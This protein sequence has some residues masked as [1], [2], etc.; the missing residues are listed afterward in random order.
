MKY[1]TLSILLIIIVACSN[2]S[3]DLK[4]DYLVVN[5]IR[6]DTSYYSTIR[7][8]LNDSLIRTYRFVGLNDDFNV[9]NKAPSSEYLERRSSEAFYLSNLLELRSIINKGSSWKS[10]YDTDFLDSLEISVFDIVSDTLIGDIPVR[11]CIIYKMRHDGYSAGE[12]YLD[13]KLFFD[14]DNFIPLKK[15][16]YND[17]KMIGEEICVEITN[18]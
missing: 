14:A 17:G 1:S 15:I 2:E 9:D 7:Q 5:H 13:F 10:L 3:K 12:D 6:S 8:I 16:Y 11:K 18:L 4:I